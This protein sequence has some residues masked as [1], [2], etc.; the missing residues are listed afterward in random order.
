MQQKA[1]VHKIYRFSFTLEFADEEGTELAKEAFVT[2]QE[3]AYKHIQFFASCKLIFFV[4]ALIM[5]VYYY[6]KVGLT[7]SRYIAASL[8]L[9]GSWRAAGV[10]STASRA[11]S[12][13]Q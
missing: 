6:S 11:A 9:P 3:R 1:I 5:T 4:A 12:A 10:G 2:V 13:L 7:R 8:L